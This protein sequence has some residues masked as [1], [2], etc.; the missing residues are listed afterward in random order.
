MTNEERAV[1]ALE[2]IAVSLGHILSAIASVDSSDQ[3][4][5]IAEAA[6]ALR[7]M[8]DSPLA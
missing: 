4:E 7:T 2:S 6:V 8:D 5:G 1:A 3:P